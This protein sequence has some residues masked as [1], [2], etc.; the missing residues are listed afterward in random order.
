M[1]GELDCQ[2][3]WCTSGT[4]EAAQFFLALKWLILP[5]MQLYLEIAA[6]TVRHVRDYL[7]SVGMERQLGLMIGSIPPVWEQV[8]QMRISEELLC[9]L[10]EF[11]VKG[12][13]VV[14]HLGLF[15]NTEVLLDYSDAF[16][17]DSFV[18]IS[19]QIPLDKV[20]RFSRHLG[21]TYRDGKL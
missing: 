7:V 18:Y 6:P 1:D 3:T 12:A 10:A 11:S 16:M 20:R 21:V 13:L 8:Y 19:K 9:D 5:D 15:R 2:N 17:R 4:T 14:D